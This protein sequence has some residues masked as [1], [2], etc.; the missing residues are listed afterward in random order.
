MC[1]RMS[2]IVL[3]MHC[4]ENAFDVEEAFKDICCSGKLDFCFK[5]IS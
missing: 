1:K 2:S 5:C 4:C 3:K